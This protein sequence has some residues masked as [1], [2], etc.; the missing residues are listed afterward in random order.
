VILNVAH[1]EDL[2]GRLLIDWLQIELIFK[3]EGEFEQCE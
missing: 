3:R 2:T 1:S